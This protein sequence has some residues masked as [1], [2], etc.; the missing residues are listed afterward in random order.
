MPYVQIFRLT[1]VLYLSFLFTYRFSQGIM[2]GMGT[3]RAIETQR[4]ALLRH[5]AGWLAVVEFVSGGPFALPL[6]RW[7]RAFLDTLLIRAELAAHYLL[8]ASAKMQAKC[9]GVVFDGFRQDTVSRFEGR[10]SDFGSERDAPSS[11]ALR[12]RLVALRTLLKNLH[13]EARRLMQKPTSGRGTRARKSAPSVQSTRYR[14]ATVGQQW[15]APRLERP[16]DREAVSPIALDFDVPSRGR[17]GNQKCCSKG[18]RENNLDS[19]SSLPCC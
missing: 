7:F 9:R 13:S 18:F 6:P 11:E 8:V 17:D 19:F 5:L 2:D 1:N 16:P 12:R 4:D 14:L 3:E 15:V 10:L